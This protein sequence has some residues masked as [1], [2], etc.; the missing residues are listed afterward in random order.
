MEGDGK[1]VVAEQNEVAKIGMQMMGV[2]R[3][4]SSAK[5]TRIS[6]LLID[7]RGGAGG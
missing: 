2:E 7:A 5:S 1:R 3:Q 4:E 6:P